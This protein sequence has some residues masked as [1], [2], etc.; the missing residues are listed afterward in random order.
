MQLGGTSAESPF[1]IYDSANRRSPV[2]E[3]LWALIRYRSLVGELVAR[4]IK[5]RYKR[6]FLGVAW[7]M[8][9]PLLTMVV[10]TLVFSQIFGADSRAYPLLVLSGLILWNFFAQSTMAAMNDL[11]W[12]GGL[13]G[14]IFVPKSVFAVAAVAT[15]LVNL[16]LALIPYLLI[17]LLLGGNLSWRLLGLPLPILIT[18]MF[19]LGVG[20]AMSRLAVYFQ[21][22]MPMY[23][24]LLTAWMYLTPVI[25]PL[26]ILPDRLESV[27]RL[28]PMS[29]QVELFRAMLY[30]GQWPATGSLMVAFGLASLTLLA[31]WLIF[32]SGVRSYAYRI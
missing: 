26:S 30:Q 11:M 1:P 8:I 9:N 16:G 12:S 5:T 25:Y 7:T 3:E 13:I 32:T 14:R 22:V 28:N 29:L 27:L 31:G 4:S 2:V 18:A 15:G 20:L 10:L 17:A 6:S 23:E 21:D 19:T 24:I